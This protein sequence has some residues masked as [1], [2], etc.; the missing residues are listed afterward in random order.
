MCID[1][2]RQADENN[3]ASAGYFLED[4]SRYFIARFICGRPTS[5]Q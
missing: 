3:E 1:I 2:P 4:A 5:R